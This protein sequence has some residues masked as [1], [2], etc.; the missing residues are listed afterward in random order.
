MGDLHSWTGLRAAFAECASEYDDLS[1]EYDSL[2]EGEWILRDGSPR[3]HRKFKDLGAA[4]TAKLGASITKWVDG[5]SIEGLTGEHT[6]RIKAQLLRADSLFWS[7]PERQGGELSAMKLAFDGVAKVLFDADIL[8]RKNLHEE[9]PILVWDTA[10]AGGWYRLASEIP[11][12]IFPER[13]GHYYVWRDDTK[14]WNALFRAETGKWL[15]E[16]L[17]KPG[18]DETGDRAVAEKGTAALLNGA[19]PDSSVDVMLPN[20]PPAKSEQTHKPSNT[21]PLDDPALRPPLW[22]RFSFEKGSKT[23]RFFPLLLGYHVSISIPAPHANHDIVARIARE[24]Q[25]P[26]ESLAAELDQPVFRRGQAIFAYVG[27]ALDEIARDYPYMRWW[28][29]DSG[30]NMVIVSSDEALGKARSTLIAERAAR[31]QT[32]VMPILA[33]KGWKR[34]R[35]VTEVGVGKGSVYAYLDGTRATI[36]DKNRKAIADVL[37]LQPEQLPD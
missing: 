32:V 37:G 28:V 12:K 26:I 24:S 34:G 30:L 22:R 1:A 25:I 19:N 8:T 6:R 13:L 36:T 20:T 29:S 11:K 16:L 9:I 27:D 33:K 35:L 15:A 3:S 4:A 14:D 2:Y 7:S 5:L 10:I 18:S 23:S 31:R 17:D 21:D